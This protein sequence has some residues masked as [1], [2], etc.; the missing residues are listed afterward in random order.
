MKTF[1]RFGQPTF[2]IALMFSLMFLYGNLQATEVNKTFKAMDTVEIKTVSGDCEVKTGKGGEIKVTVVYSY[3]TERF[4]P[5]FKE[6]G[7]ALI[8][9][10]EFHCTGHKESTS[11]KSK[12]TVTVPVKTNIE[13]ASASGDLKIDGLKSEV[14]AKTASGDIKLSSI[15][16]TLKIKSASGDI[17]VTGSTGDIKIKSASGDIKLQNAGGELQVKT[18][19]GDVKANGI[20]LE[21]ESS[22]ASVS[23]EVE[24]K[25]T[26]SLT[27]DLEI[28]TVSGDATLD[29]NGNPVKGHFVFKGMVKNFNCPFPFDEGDSSKY[30]PFGKKSFTKDGDSPKIYLKAVSGELTLKK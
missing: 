11:G 26:K 23:G 15:N 13:F 9:K 27:V 18:A 22:L 24:I 28:S 14:E 29:Y 17:H 20:E 3:P 6:E 4:E 25:L 16:G 5:I 30:S 7:G 12:W 21:K 8:L 10:E 19:S 1:K 2:I